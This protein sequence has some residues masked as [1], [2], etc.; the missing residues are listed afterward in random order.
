MTLFSTE[1][2]LARRI[3]KRGGGDGKNV[4][5]RIATIT[6]A[7]GIAV[8]IVAVAVISGFRSE[9]VGK[10]SGFGG[11]VKVVSVEGNNSLESVPISRD[12]SLERQIAQLPYYKSMRPFAVKGAIFKTDQAMQGVMLKGMDGGESWDF[13][14]GLLVRGA[15]PRIVDSVR[16]KDLLISLS[17]AQMMKIDTGS[18]VELMFVQA[19]SMP[20]RDR[21]KVCGVYDSQFNQMD[22]YVTLTDTR[23]VQRVNSWDSTQISGYELFATSFDDASRL[24]SGVYD[25]LGEYKTQ[26]LISEEI[27]ESFPEMFDWLQAHR[28]NGIVVI[29]IMLI[30]ALF[31]MISALLIILLERTSMIGTLKALGMTNRALQV[32]FL[33]RSSAIVFRGIVWGNVVGVGVCLVQKYTHLVTLDPSA[34]FLSSVPIELGFGW[35]ALLNAGTFVL[36][37]TLLTVPTLIVSYIKPDT[38]LRYQ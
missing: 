36:I 7:I 38:T 32:V 5:V 29:T 16:T 4:M 30:V 21:F 19:G 2:F 9:I 22:K 26:N 18:R 25:L 13:F 10:L 33:I 34:Y 35:W 23:N 6:V 12:A 37:V 1:F 14:E 8:M 3:S 28:V 20:R 15:V 17:L 24:N 27:S 31:N 11:D